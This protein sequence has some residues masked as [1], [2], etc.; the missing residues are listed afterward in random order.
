MGAAEKELGRAARVLA[1]VR[2]VPA[3][4]VA[5]YGDLDP[6]APR[7]AGFVLATTDADV[8]W[9]RIVRADGSAPKGERQLKLLRQE[10]VPL[11]GDR[12]DLRRARHRDHRWF[13]TR[14]LAPRA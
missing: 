9:H 8:P 6:E 11:R 1:R 14:D 5:T 2:Q 12:V 13:S 10:G 7:F 3:G 4:R